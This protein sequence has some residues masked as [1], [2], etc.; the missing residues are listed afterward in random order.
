MA[1]VSYAVEVF[2]NLIFVGVH[3]KFEVSDL[4]E[5]KCYVLIWHAFNY[6]VFRR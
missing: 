3:Y 6:R 1:G 5:G 4:F 2:R